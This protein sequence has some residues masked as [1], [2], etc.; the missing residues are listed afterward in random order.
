[1]QLLD[2]GDM[3]FCGIDEA[4][5][6]GGNGRIPRWLELAEETEEFRR[7]AERPGRTNETRSGAKARKEPEEAE[8]VEQRVRV[9]PAVGRR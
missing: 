3:L 6:D 5:M 1:V 7:R 4:S 2:D 8:D 9:E